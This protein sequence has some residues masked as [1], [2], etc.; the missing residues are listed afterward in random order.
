MRAGSFFPGTHYCSLYAMA[1]DDCS[2]HFDLDS[3]TEKQRADHESNVELTAMLQVALALIGHNKD[4]LALY[5][6]FLES[7]WRETLER[8]HRMFCHMVDDVVPLDHLSYH[9]K[10]TFY[11][12]VAAY[13]EKHP[14]LTDV[15]NLYMSSGSNSVIHQ[16]PALLE[17]NRNVNSKKHFAEHAATYGLPVPDTL[18]TTKGELGGTETAAFFVKHD[19]QVIAKL[20]GLAGARNVAP[21]SSVAETEKFVDEY[22]DDMIVL[23]QQRL[24]TDKYTEMTV[25]LLVSDTEVRIANV[26]KILFADGLW[27][28]NLIGD[29]VALTDAQQ[30]QLVKV[31]EYARHHGYTST[32]GS[33]CGVDFFIGHDGT[34]IV[35]EINARWTGGLFPAEALSQLDK[36]LTAGRDAVPFFD[37]V[38]QSAL[39]A[40]LGFMETYL[41]GTSHER[42]S[43][44]PLGFGPFDVPIEGEDHIYTWQMVVG[45]FN[46]F[47]AAKKTLGSGVMPTADAISP[48]D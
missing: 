19:N 36:N 20:L 32:E 26:R 15:A 25:D 5:D 24:S 7:P 45:D 43:M 10:Y 39:E 2:L 29:T 21:V 33:N 40:Y 28:G 11:E 17:I 38:R 16:D 27:V 3:L 48:R 37:V 46:A 4:H 42:F 9:P 22:D 41:I 6:A 23:L 18:V 30:S 1:G 47:K 12:S 8:Y 14:D 35:T 44:V 31:G 34:L 13:I